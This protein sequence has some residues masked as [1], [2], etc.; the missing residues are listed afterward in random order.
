[1]TAFDE[2]LVE[3]GRALGVVDPAPQGGKRRSMR[4]TKAATPRR[5]R[6]AS[7]RGALLLAVW[8]AVWAAPAAADFRTWLLQQA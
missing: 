2:S 8:M 7:R 4:R 1:M 5:R 3:L 6:C